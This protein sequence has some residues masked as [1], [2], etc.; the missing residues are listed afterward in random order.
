MSFNLSLKIAGVKEAID[1]LGQFS[2]DVMEGTNIALEQIGNDL[3]NE[4]QATCPVDTG[5][6]QSNIHAEMEGTDLNV[7]SD[8]E[9]SGFVEYGTWKTEP[10]PYFGPAI[11][12]I[13]SG[14]GLEDVGADALSNFRS[15]A[16]SV[17]TP[18]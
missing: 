4:M 9:Y 3:V 10:Q 7:S 1:A 2:D 5:N 18:Q 14:A 6:L 16:S 13:R 11:D 8:A 17:S 15:A 12:K